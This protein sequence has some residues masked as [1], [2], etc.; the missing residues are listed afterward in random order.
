VILIVA[1]EKYLSSVPILQITMTFTFLR[2]F[3]TQFGYTMDSVGKPQINFLINVLLLFVSVGTTYFGIRQF[4]LMGPAYASIFTW[5][6]ACIIFYIILKKELGIQVKNI[7]A[8]SLATY[9]DLFK[10]I[11]NFIKRPKAA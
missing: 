8:Y 3:F 6:F 5:A 10:L 1:G 11:S 4:G 9:K 7:F 2:P